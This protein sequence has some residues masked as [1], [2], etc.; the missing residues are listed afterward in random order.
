MKANITYYDCVGKVL[1]TYI[2]TNKVGAQ[3]CEVDNGSVAITMAVESFASFERSMP[4]INCARV[5][6]EDLSYETWLS[7]D[8]IK[9]NIAQ[10]TSSSTGIISS[11]CKSPHKLL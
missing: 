2:I 10:C 6:V 8:F 1:K 7:T 4:V 9:T 11:T 3:V 5:I